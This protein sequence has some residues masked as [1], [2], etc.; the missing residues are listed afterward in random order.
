M[1]QKIIIGLLLLA[2]VLAF[3]QPGSGRGSGFSPGRRGVPDWQLDNEMPLDVFTFVRIRY[4]SWG[5]RGRKWATDYPNADL[6]FSFRLQELTSL[7]V[8]PDGKVI[9]LTDPALFDYPFIYIIEPGDL[10]FSDEEVAALRD[11]GVMYGQ[12]YYFA[13]PAVLAEA[14]DSARSL[15]RFG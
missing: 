4:N 15:R 1:K 9:E 10:W 8:H 14:V 6:N 7:K 13:R 3:A 11:L 12:G 5:G 2:M